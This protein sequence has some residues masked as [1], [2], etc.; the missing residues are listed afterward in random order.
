MFLKVSLAG[1]KRKGVMVGLLVIWALLG[2]STGWGYEEAPVTDG[3]VLEGKV[4]LNGPPPPARIFH[5]IFSPN[6]DFCGRISD[7]K[8]N[9]LLKDFQVAP[10]GGL[11]DVVVAVVGV[12]QGKPFSYTP[13]ITIENCRIAPWV[14]PVRNGHPFRMIN[15][16]P[17][18]HDVQGYTLKDDYTFAMFNK[19][20]TPE[21]MATKTVRLRNGH[22][23]FR[24]Q[25]GVHDFMQSWGMAVGNPYFAVTGAD[26][27]FTIPDLPPGEYDVLA[28][29]PHVKV[30]AGQ[31]KIEPNGKAELNFAFEAEEIDIPLHDLQTQFRLDTALQPRHLVPPSVELQ[32]Y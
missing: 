18:A 2:P 19:P 8:G 15:N 25:C 30:R 16:D 3:G 31:I 17:I 24:T 5:L 1:L 23:L 4:V 12:Q 27:R 9:R 13:E 22:Y 14:T 7:G 6:I 21:T 20:L 10:D 29:H 11:K 32:Q 28:W 26:G